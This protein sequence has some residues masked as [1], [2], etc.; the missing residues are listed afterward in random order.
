MNSIP[1]ASAPQAIASALRGLRALV[2]ELPDQDE[3]DTGKRGRACFALAYRP[4]PEK[5]CS[6]LHFEGSG[7][8]LAMNRISS[9]MSPGEPYEIRWKRAAGRIGTFEAHPRFMDHRTEVVA[10]L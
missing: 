2:R 4:L 7:H 8:A 6:A 9:V 5:G 1:K 3:A 10:S